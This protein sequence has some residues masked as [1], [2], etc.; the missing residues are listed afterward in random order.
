MP[1]LTPHAGPTPAPPSNASIA[2]LN[3]RLNAQL[4][5]GGAVAYSSK[6]YV[7]DLQQAVDEAKAQY[8]KAAAPPPDVLAKA[9]YV[10]RQRGTLLGPPSILY[11]IKKRRI[12]G[13][14]ICT[15]WLVQQA[16]GGGPPQGGFTIGPC[17]GDEF[18]PSGG[19]PTLPPHPS[20]APS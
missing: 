8:F 2:D 14:E 19:L 18:S 7:N 13:F 11:V 6:A 12:F 4:P 10:V 9:L 1:A 17:G 5:Q 3:A 16:A 20:P 15:G